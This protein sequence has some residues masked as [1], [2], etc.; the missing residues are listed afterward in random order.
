V[1]YSFCLGAEATGA[2]DT[3]VVLLLRKKDTVKD[4]IAQTVLFANEE[5][6]MIMRQVLRTLFFMAAAIVIM[7][8]RPLAVSAQPCEEGVPFHSQMAWYRLEQLPVPPGR[9]TEPLPPPFQYLW[10]TNQ[11]GTATSTHLGTGP[12]FVEL[13]VYGILTNPGAPPPANGTPTGFNSILYELTAANGDQL[14]ATG[15]LIGVVTDPVFAF[16]ITAE[17]QDGGTG[18]FTN[19]QGDA[20]GFVTP[21]PFTTQVGSEV[22]DGCILYKRK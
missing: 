3:S 2:E 16:V 10:W 12:Y 11:W 9:C 8:V 19:A 14:I 18:R 7:L 17:F 1:I 6:A 13:C 15:T 21:D 22:Y 4:D 5:I 20:L